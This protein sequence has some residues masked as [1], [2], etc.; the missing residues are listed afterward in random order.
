MRSK[1]FRAVV[2]QDAR[3][4]SIVCIGCTFS[5]FYVFLLCLLILME[6]AFP[7]RFIDQLPFPIV[8]PLIV[9]SILCSFIYDLPMH[10]LEIPLI[11]SRVAVTV[12]CIC[13]AIW[14]LRKI[15]ILTS[16]SWRQLLQYTAVILFIVLCTQGLV[17][18][19]VPLRLAFDASRLPFEQLLNDGAVA[20]NL[21]Q[22]EYL[23]RECRGRCTHV[24]VS[25]H[26]E[27]H[28]GLYF[29][30]DYA[31]DSRGGA[32]FRVSTR[33]PGFMPYVYSCGFVTHPNADGTPFGGASYTLTE[34]LPVPIIGPMFLRASAYSQMSQWY[35]FC[36]S[37]DY[38]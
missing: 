18:S 12:A 23:H 35:W 31:A 6:N 27:R 17:R 20:H 25:M 15:A 11:W 30:R 36:V 33:L 2:R 7:D 16:T 4:S 32:Y 3:C 38:Y 26:F 19:N 22:S 34:I 37:D 24:A 14:S 21:T 9:G 8:P 10:V 1:R 29:V 5:V 28:V 13:F